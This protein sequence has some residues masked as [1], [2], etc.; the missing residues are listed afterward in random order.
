MDRFPQIMS[1]PGPIFVTGHTGFKGSW[2]TSI[3]D[4]LEIPWFGYSLAPEKD[5]LYSRI[6]KN[7]SKVETFADVRDYDK[8]LQQINKVKPSAIIHLAAQPLVLRSYLEPRYTFEVNVM[9]SVNVLEAARKIESVK[10]VVVATTDKVYQNL[11]QGDPFNEQDCLGGHDPYSSSKTGTEMAVEAWRNL[12]DSGN[13]VSISSARAGNVIGG[14]D[15][16]ENR[17]LPDLIRG[18][19]D[20]R[21]V[22]IRNPISVRPWQHVIDPLLGYLAIIENG[23]QKNPPRA[24][25]FGPDEKGLSV[26][27]VVETAQNAWG[28]PTAIE[29]RS[30]NQEFHEAE[31]L[32]LNSGWARANLDWK[33]LYS[34]REAVESTVTWWKR[35]LTQD[36]SAD[37]LVNEEIIDRLN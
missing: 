30:I 22:E 35:H 11:E 14:G 23:L 37:E 5:S 31:N 16:S 20:K 19:F 12:Q 9:G 26:L 8:L 6:Q 33:N 32:E 27:E 10:Y 28:A 1:L 15:F 18:F 34:Q 2:L 4:I 36:I 13:N 7:Y 25:N 17:L 24:V 29:V 21:T 3:L